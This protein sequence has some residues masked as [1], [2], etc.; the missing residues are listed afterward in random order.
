MS[1]IIYNNILYTGTG[2]GGIRKRPVSEMITSV[3][4]LLNKIPDKF[5]LYQNYPNPFNTTTTIKF[6]LPIPSFVTLKVYDLLGEEIISLIN[7]Q[8]IAGKYEVNFNASSLSSGI[9]IYHLNANNQIATK[10]LV[11]I[12]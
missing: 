10:K 3:P 8:K 5:T 12:K 11:L 6:D 4:Y 7:E 1:L 2:G 9:Y